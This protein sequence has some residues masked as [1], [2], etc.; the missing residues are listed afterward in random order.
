MLYVHPLKKK[1]QNLLESDTFLSDELQR[2]NQ[3]FFTSLTEKWFLTPN[4]GFLRWFVFWIHHKCPE[5][6]LTCSTRTVPAAPGATPGLEQPPHHRAGRREQPLSASHKAGRHPPRAGLSRQLA[7]IGLAENG[8]HSWGRM[9]EG[10]HELRDQHDRSQWR[11]SLTSCEIWLEI[12]K[13]VCIS[14]PIL[15]LVVPNKLTTPQRNSSW[16]RAFAK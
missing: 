6:G 2:M 14:S 4:S 11:E 8:K 13:A 16:G 12:I 1:P 9:D 5:H 3:L 7:R 15:F 10:I